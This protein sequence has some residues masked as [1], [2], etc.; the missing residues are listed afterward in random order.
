MKLQEIID[1]HNKAHPGP[2]IG[3]DVPGAGFQIKAKFPQYSWTKDKLLSFF[4]MPQSSDIR[5]QLGQDGNLYG[6]IAYEEWVQFPP[7]RW[8]E[9]Q[10]A[11]C[12]AFAHSWEDIEYLLN[13]IKE[14]NSCIAKLGDD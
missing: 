6:L 1:R 7:N 3:E 12:E 9:M 14:L 4:R 8:E 10:K 2:Y 11:N 13:K 5:F